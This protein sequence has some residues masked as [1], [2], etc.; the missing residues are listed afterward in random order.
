MTRRVVDPYGIA[1][2]LG[3]WYVVG[4]CHLRHGIRSFRLDRVVGL[5]SGA[6][7]FEAPTGFDVLGHLT[8]GIA[9][10]PSRHVLE[11]EYD[12]SPDVLAERVPPAYAVLEP[13]AGG[14]LARY[15]ADDLDVMASYLVSL[16]LPFRV[17]A[18][19]ELRVALR[20]LADRVLAATEV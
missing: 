19:S 16:H 14:T 7:R 8:R 5:E 9:T 2:T 15:P 12:V 18:P 20:R 17:R 4:W 1:A 13:I 3:H 6:E 11:V 10:M